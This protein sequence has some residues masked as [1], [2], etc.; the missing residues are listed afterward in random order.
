MEEARST[1]GKAQGFLAGIEG[2]AD[3]KDRIDMHDL[4]RAT[5]R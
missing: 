4:E 2:L 1:A 3:D 5:W